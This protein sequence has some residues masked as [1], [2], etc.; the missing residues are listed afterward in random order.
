MP[1]GDMGHGEMHTMERIRY[2][3]LV[4]LVFLFLLALTL[5]KT[6]TP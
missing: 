6:A 5:T 2:G 4:F 3:I 1:E